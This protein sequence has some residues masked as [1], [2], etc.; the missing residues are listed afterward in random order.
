MTW[1]SSAR[2][3][4]IVSTSFRSYPAHAPTFIFLAAFLKRFGVPDAKST[5]GYVIPAEWQS[6]LSNGSSAGG[7]IGL[8]LN[9]M[10]ADRY[11]PKIV[12][13]TSL[14]ALTGFIFIMVFA[15]SLEMLVIGKPSTCR[16]CYLVHL[17]NGI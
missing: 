13:M 6:A 3:T 5:N 14:V 11:G 1:S 2:S 8:L 15:N 12:M 4:A 7:I 9:G 10:A 16:F 17:L